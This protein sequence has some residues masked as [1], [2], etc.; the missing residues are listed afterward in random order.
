MRHERGAQLRARLGRIV[1]LEPVAEALGRRWHYAWVVLASAIFIMT[2]SAGVRNSFGV[3]V[4]PL[5]EQFGWKVGAVSF[6]YFILFVS[7]VPLTLTGGWLADRFG[8]RPVAICA[9]SVFILGLLLTAVVSE[10]WQFYLFYATLVGGSSVV[11]TTLLPVTMTQWFHRRM[12]TAVGLAFA[13][14]G[15]G[16]FVLALAFGWLIASSGWTTTFLLVGALGGI[17]LL[18]AALL[19]RSRPSAMGLLAY[20]QE[21]PSAPVSARARPAPRV[22]LGQIRRQRTIWLLIGI[23]FLGC[24]G[25]AVPL[26]H[27]VRLAVLKGTPEV[28]AAGMLST[29]SAFSIASRLGV[30][31]LVERCNAKL[32]LTLG[33]GLQCTAV[34]LYLW[35]DSVV[36]LYLISVIF[37]L[38][39][40]AEMS[41]FPLLNRQYYGDDA[42]LNSLHAWE[43]AGAMVGMGIGGWLGGVL[44]D[45]TGSYA[46]SIGF[47]VLVGLAAV[48]LIL[49]L[50]RQSDTPLFAAPSRARPATA[51]IHLEHG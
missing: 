31:M 3:F 21:A 49:A 36:A 33:Y 45:L 20:G 34:L 40:G 17:P 27:L 2:I 14:G 9:A 26:A 22:D 28:L 16:P 30:P 11:F 50:P 4:S 1:T 13:A 25:H 51:D 18:G 6:A 39:F 29:V 19:I 42:P 35:A 43:M 12:G 5:V 41:A 46:A 8:V 47:A 15:L 7:G 44:F 37:G 23:H 32:V 24:V 38:A 10:L 48:P